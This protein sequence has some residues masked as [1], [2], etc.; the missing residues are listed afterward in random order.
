MKKV[1]VIGASG[2]AGS[3]AYKLASSK[4][5]LEVTGIVRHKEKAEKVLGKDA[6]LIYGDVLTMNDSLL[7]KFDIIVDALGT[8]PDEADQQVTLSKKL[9]NLARHNKI[10]LIFILGAGSL[11]TGEDKHL[12]VDDIEKMPGSEEWIN[13]PKEQ[14]EELEYLRGVDD[15]DWMGI[16]P[17]MEFVEGPEEDY[18]VGEDELL[19]D[20]DG[21]SKV[22]SGTMAKVIVDEIENPEY[23]RER[24]TIV[25][26]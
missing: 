25:N 13:I 11:V 3:A 16:S 8:T 22:T 18:E 23:T 5:N 14:L 9:V 12:V 17:A 1:A 24:I 26:K 10:K 15:V 7:E 2:M 19:Y 20:D 4:P 6:N 21:N